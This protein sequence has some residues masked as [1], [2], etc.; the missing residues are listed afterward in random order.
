MNPA[1]LAEGVNSSR[2][3][4]HLVDMPFMYHLFD[5]GSNPV[6]KIRAASQLMWSSLTLGAA[7][8]AQPTSSHKYVSSLRGTSPA[9]SLTFTICAVRQ[10]PSD[11]AAGSTSPLSDPGYRQRGQGR[12]DRLVGACVLLMQPSGQILTSSY[13]RGRISSANACRSLLSSTSAAA[14]YFILG[15]SRP[16]LAS[17]HAPPLR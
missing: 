13:R 9:P 8:C 3:T 14:I 4:N 7:R 5:L 16:P 6:E 11:D 10:A 12:H 15:P 17:S 2:L 1:T